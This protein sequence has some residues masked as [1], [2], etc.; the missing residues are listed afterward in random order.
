ML[1]RSCRPNPTRFGSKAF[2]GDS[3]LLK[4]A[5]HGELSVKA[6]ADPDAPE[7]T[8]EGYGSKFGLVDS[9]GESVVA[10][11]FKKSLREWKKRK[12]P[13]PMLWQ[14][15]SRMP[16]GGWHS[17]EEDEIGLKLIG[18]INV[19]TQ[20]GREALSDVK[21]ETVGGLSIGYYEIK[22]DPF[23]W[24]AQEEPRKLYEL[25]LRETSVVT[26]P[27]LREAQ[28]DAVKARIAR[29][30]ALTEREFEKFL[31]EKLNLSR[32]D[33]ETV[34]RIGYRAWR[35]REVGQADAGDE[36]MEEIRSIRSLPPLNL[37]TL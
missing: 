1:T 31:R 4:K 30:E 26:F 34:N 16:I 33:A 28:I 24:E 11:A 20:R 32:S 37:P 18:L 23:S 15:D 5:S 35:Q 14:H 13:I 27:A 36:A 12:R 17:Y 19:E 25:D 2:D 9:Y 29:G 8:I 10:G 3:D 6:S 21:A 22:A 7:G